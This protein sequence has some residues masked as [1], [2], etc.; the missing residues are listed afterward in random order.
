MDVRKGEA[1][2]RRA[3]FGGNGTVAVWDLLGAG[4]APPFSAVLSC[5]LEPGGS[6]GV[7]RQ[8]RDPEIVIGLAG[9]GEAEVD[10]A[11]HRLAPGDVVYLPF[12]ALLAIRNLSSEESLGYLI[13]KAE[14]HVTES[15]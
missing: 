2:L 10:G 7:H 3:L 5:E 13:V 12:G 14:R 4:A 15:Q 8:Q 11:P 9:R 6:V 1:T